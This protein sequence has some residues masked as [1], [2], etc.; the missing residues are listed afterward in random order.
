MLNGKPLYSHSRPD[1]YRPLGSHEQF[2]AIAIGSGMAVERFAV[3]HEID[4][5][6]LDRRHQL[7]QLRFKLIERGGDEPVIQHGRHRLN[8]V[9]DLVSLT[10]FV[11]LIGASLSFYNGIENK[12]ENRV[13]AVA[14]MLD[15]RL[16]T[17]S[18]DISKVVV[19]SRF[20]S[21]VATAR[22][23]FSTLF[24]MLL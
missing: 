18:F 23:R 21:M 12:V 10:I 24:S 14:T 13:Q 22:T 11:T 16:I 19:I 3:E 4:M 8:A 2:R 20:S 5:H 9:F 15:N 6:D 17:T 1:S 7:I